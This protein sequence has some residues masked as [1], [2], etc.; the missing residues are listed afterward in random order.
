MADGSR[1]RRWTVLVVVAGAMAAGLLLRHFHG[2]S[3]ASQAGPLG[4][5]MHSQAKQL[6]NVPFVTGDGASVQLADL[7]G[8][9]LLLNIWATWCPPCIEELP[10][11]NAFSRAQETNGVVVIGA[12]ADEEGART[13]APLTRREGL[14]Y[15]ILLANT[16]VQMT[17]GISAFP[18]TI[19]IGPDGRVAARYLGSLTHLELDRAIAPLLKP[20][21]PPVPSTP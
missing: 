2:S 19:I 21:S 6:D 15:P 3:G 18:T 1:A 12:A 9:V 4:F 13:V 5:V 16:N 11:L 7:K 10:V 14:A 8:K 20:P 17:F